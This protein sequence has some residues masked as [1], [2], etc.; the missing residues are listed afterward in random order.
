VRPFSQSAEVRCRG[1]SNLL[2]RTIADFGSDVSFQRIPK[3]IEE[4]Y[5]IKIPISSAQE[6][7]EKYAETIDEME[8]IQTEMPDKKA[9]DVIIAQVDGSMIPI[10]KTGIKEE[11]D[12][13][14]L[15]KTRKLDWKEARLSIA[16]EKGSIKKTYGT[17]IGS[18]DD[19]GDQLC[20]CVIKV[21][22]GTNTRIH[23]VGD[24][25]PWIASQ[26]ERVFGLQGSF[27]LDFYHLCDYLSAAGDVC[28]KEDDKKS[29]MEQQ[30]KKMKQNEYAEVLKDL[31]PFMENENTPN[32]DAAVR[33]C[34]RYIVSRTEQLD[35]KG[36]I[37]SNLP[38]GSGEVESGHRYII[39]ERLKIS[40]AWWKLNNAK[41]MLA[42][43]VLRANNKWEDYWDNLDKKAA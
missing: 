1:Y 18:A 13:T 29:W 33:A 10:V 22:A 8:D 2:Q 23:S 31:E 11:S 4:H 32:K 38:I 34:Y 37:E 40:G 7:T 27:L 6:I 9:V 28:A 25:A 42:L 30:K 43:R 21:G 35:Y 16:Y 5:G 20:N 26:I 24:G 3:K 14:D 39:Q 15:R 17:T 41:S 36:A 19:A 12:N